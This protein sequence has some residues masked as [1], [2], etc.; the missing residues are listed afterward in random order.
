M[1]LNETRH[2]SL[3]LAFGVTAEA[4]T[5]GGAVYI[6]WIV[7]EDE[8]MDTPSGYGRNLVE[9]LKVTPPRAMAAT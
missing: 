9:A 1:E 7:L 6:D 4:S 2:E 3:L 5:S 8:N